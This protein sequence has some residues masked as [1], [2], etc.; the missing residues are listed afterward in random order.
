MEKVPNGEWINCGYTCKNEVNIN[1]YN[2]N[3]RNVK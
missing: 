3:M 2:M 1:I